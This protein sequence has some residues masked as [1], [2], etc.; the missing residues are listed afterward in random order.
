MEMKDMIDSLK[1]DLLVKRLFNDDVAKTRA[2]LTQVI[3]TKVLKRVESEKSNML[4][5][6]ETADVVA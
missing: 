3:R 5:K 2:D 1:G 4:K 6:K